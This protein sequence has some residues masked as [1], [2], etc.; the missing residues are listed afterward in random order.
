MNYLIDPEDVINYERSDAEL[1]L[2]WMFSCV[3]AGKTA[4]TQAKLLDAMLASLPGESPFD[5]IRKLSYNQLRDVLIESRLGQYNRLIRTFWQS[6]DLDLRNCSIED[7]EAVHGVGPKTARMFVMMS[8][9]GQRCAALDT[10]VLKHLRANGIDAPL[11]TPPGGKRYREL[12]KAFIALADEA[13]QSVADYDLAVW[14]QHAR[15]E[16]A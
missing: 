9:P 6:L 7:L 5:K 3:V 14:K 4:R 16:A 2:W 1:E 8:R 12:E 15:K 10:H 13:G 11:A